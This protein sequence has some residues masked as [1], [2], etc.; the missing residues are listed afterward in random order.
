MREYSE[1][2]LEKF[3][4]FLL[5]YYFE[6]ENEKEYENKPLREMVQE[7]TKAW[8]HEEEKQKEE[9]RKR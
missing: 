8:L 1:S 4:I 3:G 5:A 2:E 6:K 9:L 7:A